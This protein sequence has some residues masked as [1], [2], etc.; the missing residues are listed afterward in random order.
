MT[1]W[2]VLIYGVLVAAGGIMGYLKAGSSASLA[3]GLIAG[4]ALAGSS[5]SMMK[6]SYQTGWWVALVVTILLLARFGM[7]ALKG[8]KMMPGGMVIIMSLVVLAV[9]LTQR[10]R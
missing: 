3:A 7:A 9:L 5:Y 1:S 8:F 4:A 10:G 2:I 6:G